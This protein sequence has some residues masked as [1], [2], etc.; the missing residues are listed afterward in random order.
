MK[1][2]E[3]IQNVFPIE[4]QSEVNSLLTKITVETRFSHKW[5]IVFS[6]ATGTDTFEQNINRPK[7]HKNFR[8][9]K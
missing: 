9:D 6:R 8:Y 7:G 3:I 1:E 4:I 5:G 2:H